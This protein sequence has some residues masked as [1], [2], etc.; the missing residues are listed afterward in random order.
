[1]LNTP[2]DTGSPL[3]RKLVV[4]AL[5]LTGA[6]ILLSI[7][8][9]AAGPTPLVYVAL[10]MIVAGLT[11]HIAGLVIRARDARRRHAGQADPQRP[12]SGH[13]GR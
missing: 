12:A 5:L 1:M 7:A 11:A 6:G 2:W 3:Y 13:A 8:G 9:A 10:P 4:S